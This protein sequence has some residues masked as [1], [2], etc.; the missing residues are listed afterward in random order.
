MEI[1]TDDHACPDCP[2]AQANG[3]GVDPE[4]RTGA[5]PKSVFIFLKA[6]ISS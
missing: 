6:I 2:V 5:K 3:T 1:V 4:D